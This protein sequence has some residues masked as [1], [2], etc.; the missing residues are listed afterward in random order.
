MHRALSGIARVER[1]LRIHLLVIVEDDGGTVGQQ[2]EQLAEETARESRHVVLVFG[3]EQR[4]GRPVL[5]GERP[6]RLPEI[7]EKRR[8][9]GV[10]SIDLVPDAGNLPAIQPCPHHRR[11]ASTRR[12]YDASSRLAPSCPV[13]SGKQP[14]AFHRLVKTRTGQFCKRARW[15]GHENPTDSFLPRQ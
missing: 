8:R 1:V 13:Q 10:A 14:A 5:P 12:A 15:P 4:Q 9:I 2:T 7:V 11:L 6:A 3:G